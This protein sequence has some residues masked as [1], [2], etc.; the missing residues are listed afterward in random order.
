LGK[1]N[2]MITKF[3]G[4]KQLRQNMAKIANEARRKNQRIIVL[5]KNQPVFELLPLSSSDSIIESFRKEIEDS[6]K[7]AKKGEIYSQ[8]MVLEELGL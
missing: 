3:V 4:T 1:K 5:R 7:Q 6:R 8:K 2:K